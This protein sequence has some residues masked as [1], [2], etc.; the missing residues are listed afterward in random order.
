MEVPSPS[1][2]KTQVPFAIQIETEI[3][4]NK[5]IKTQ[6]LKGYLTLNII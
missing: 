2:L 3:S 6:V 4:T 5:I 1:F